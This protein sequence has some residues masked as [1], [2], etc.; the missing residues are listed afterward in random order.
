MIH[1]LAVPR[2][3]PPQR[4]QLSRSAR[5][6]DAA[7]AYAEA[8]IPVFPVKPGGKAPLTRHGH[9]DAT[10][11]AE[12]IRRWWAKHP[13]ANIGA[14]TGKRTGWLVVD[15]DHPTALDALE[16]EHG[17]LPATRT[18]GT[19]SGGMHLYLSWTEGLTNSPGN[20]PIGI[21]VRGE[22]GYVVVPPSRTTRPYEVLDDLPPAEP[23]GWLLEALVTPR[24]VGGERQGARPAVVDS[25]PIPKHR[26]NDALASILGRAHDGTRDLP[27]LIE[28][29]LEARDKLMEEPGSFPDKE[30]EKTARSIHRYEPCRPAAKRAPEEVQGALVAFEDELERREWPGHSANRLS[31]AKTYILEGRRHGK[32]VE[33]GVAI[34]ISNSQTALHNGI[35][36]RSVRRNNASLVEMGLIRLDNEVRSPTESGTVVLLA[37]TSV[38][39][40]NHRG[41]VV[42][43]GFSPQKPAGGGGLGQNRAGS[44]LSAVRG[45]HGKPLYDGLERVGFLSRMGK[46]AE[47]AVDVLE[48][49]GGRLL[50]REL[51][52]AM[53]I[54]KARNMGRPGG[55]LSKL[56]DAGVVE[57]DGEG[58]LALTA[59]WLGAWDRRRVEGEE[60]MDRERDRERY[61]RMSEAWAKRVAEHTEKLHYKRL[62]REA[63]ACHDGELPPEAD[64]DVAELERVEDAPGEDSVYMG[65]VE[66]QEKQRAQYGAVEDADDGSLSELASALGRFLDRCPHR[67]NETPSW[68]SVALWADDYHPVRADE[69]RV[70]H[71]LGELRS[72]EGMVAA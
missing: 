54:T 12:K 26:R 43:E 4:D 66:P 5:M 10:T 70:A 37:P 56:V 47:F 25:G 68:L 11:N 44:K 29:A 67:A 51:A 50:P 28:Y 34:S 19:G 30:V 71:A 32:I 55:W 16:E 13:D 60:E 62:E 58:C 6:I 18:V 64:G 65:A 38:L 9:K 22:G 72:R 57:R 31:L 27:A 21:D 33:D 23:P 53:G 1:P 45:R 24:K 2:S 61:R 39:T 41:G 7:L 52:E 3:V 14:P 49:A 8:G 69:L 42:G 17:E 36:A 15:Q 46:R 40:H 63:L 59:D 20:L 48:H 35:T